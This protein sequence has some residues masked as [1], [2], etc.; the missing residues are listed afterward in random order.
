MWPDKRPKYTKLTH[1][2]LEAQYGPAVKKIDRKVIM[3]IGTSYTWPPSN[4]KDFTV[5]K[6]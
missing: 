5:K 4:L 1:G 2:Q 6:V 3:S